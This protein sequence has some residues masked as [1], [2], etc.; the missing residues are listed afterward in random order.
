MAPHTAAQHTT[1]ATAP[2]QLP[3]N[4][5]R[6]LASS[7]AAAYQPIRPATHMHTAMGSAW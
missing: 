1:T 6:D 5:R 4:T 7:M 3:W 2:F